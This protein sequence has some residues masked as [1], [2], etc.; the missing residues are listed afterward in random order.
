VTSLSG[1]LRDQA[2][3]DT[4]TLT[5]HVTQNHVTVTPLDPVGVAY[6]DLAS[7]QQTLVMEIIS[8]YLGT[9]PE[10]AAT[11]ILGR[12]QASGLDQIR[13]GWAG[14]LEA[15]QPHYYRLQGPTFLLEFDNSR[16]RGTHIHSVWRDFGEDF[17]HHL[18]G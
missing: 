1:P 4:R 17:G 3:F 6:T 16:N 14:A 15:R 8:T 11:S 12:V 2:I 18:V 5:Q 9:L 10:S 7:A 13:F